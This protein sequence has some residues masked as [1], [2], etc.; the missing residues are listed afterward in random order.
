MNPRMMYALVSCMV[1]LAAT[2]NGVVVAQA[3]EPAYVEIVSGAGKC[4]GVHEPDQEIDGQRKP[5][6]RLGSDN[7]PLDFP[8]DRGRDQFGKVGAVE[9][10]VGHGHRR[11]ET[12]PAQDEEDADHTPRHPSRLSLP[13]SGRRTR[14]RSAMKALWCL[15]AT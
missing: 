9:K 11:N 8:I 15:Y 10:N 3:V 14:F 5:P 4:R 2:T 12:Q 13:V 7:S 1:C 6:T